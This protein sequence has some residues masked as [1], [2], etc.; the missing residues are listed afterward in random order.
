[1]TE[2]EWPTQ[3]DLDK[4]QEL[5]GE[6]LLSIQNEFQIV[7]DPS[8][9]TD[10]LLEAIIDTIAGGD[11]TKA[12]SIRLSAVARV[13]DELLARR[14]FMIPTNKVDYYE[15]R[16]PLFGDEIRDRFPSTTFEIDEA[17]KCFALGRWTACVFHL[18]RVMEIGIQATARNLGVPDPAKPSER[19]W[20]AILR[21]MN[22]AISQKPA[23]AERD[24]LQSTYALL[25]A[26]RNAWR[27]S[28]MHVENKYIEDEAADILGAV[29]GFMRK[30]ASVFD[31][32]GDPIP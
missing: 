20:G 11:E 30:I 6:E 27:N 19:N 17:G 14:A 3:R 12:I 22:A 29:R 10:C 9:F 23:G 1:M 8:M 28:T 15:S 32:R 25:D 31:E 18:M 5:L 4:A 21:A 13:R 26:V 7:M 24:F 16:T 2:N